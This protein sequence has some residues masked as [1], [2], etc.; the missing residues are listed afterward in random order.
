M[1]RILHIVTTMDYG[2][3]ETL[4]MSIYR[5]IDRSKIQFDFLCMNTCDNLF[6]KEIYALGGR[7]YAIPFISKVGY[8][9][10]KKRL[11]SFFEKH[12]EYKIVHSHINEFNGITIQVAKCAQ[13]PVRIAH[14]HN[15]GVRDK[16]KLVSYFKKYAKSKIDCSA[17]HTFACSQKCKEE[18]HPCGQ[19]R[20]NCIVLNNAINT[21]KFSFSAHKRDD[22]RTKA[23]PPVRY[24]LGNVGSFCSQKNQMMAVKIIEE[25]LHE[26]TDI[27]LWLIGDGKD[28]SSIEEY[29]R[30]NHLQNNIFF[31]G[32]QENISDY[33][34]AMDIFLFPSNWE[35]LGIVAIEAQCNGLPVLASEAVP[36]ETRITDL[37]QYLPL[38]DLD[39]W[40]SAVRLQ[41]DQL[42]KIDRT[43]Y[44][45][46][47][48]AAGW[49]INQIV[50]QM[51]NWYLE[52]YAEIEEI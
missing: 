33:M 11:R 2:G 39:A 12:P 22:I 14:A 9:G 15:C 21:S 36:L 47:V 34:S 45:E 1:I 8:T 6:S 27:V 38:D 10:Y 44:P 35:G 3:V 48:T 18:F 4:L 50:E 31:L 29:V 19:F 49:D 16:K 13:I 40:V 41:I 46:K 32:L 37:I 30:T 24:I 23:S 26:R 5:N 42:D 7:M 20:K 43:K 25:L 28:R 52:R 17:T 51:Q